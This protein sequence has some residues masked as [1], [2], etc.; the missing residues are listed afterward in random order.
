MV[1]AVESAPALTLICSGSGRSEGTGRA[2][3][4]S[5]TFFRWAN[6][7]MRSTTNPLS[8]ENCILFAYLGTPKQLKIHRVS[9]LALRLMAFSL[10]KL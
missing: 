2:D 10:E 7:S 1:Q 4:F 5:R 6:L 9:E 8:S 3:K